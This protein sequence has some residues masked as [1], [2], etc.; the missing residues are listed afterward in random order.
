[1]R[2][3]PNDQTAPAV[4]EGWCPG[5]RGVIGLTLIL[6]ALCGQVSGGPLLWHHFIS[7]TSS[8]GDRRDSSASLGPPS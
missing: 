3:L 6:G 7:N 2:L 1:M 4:D 8:P 5:S